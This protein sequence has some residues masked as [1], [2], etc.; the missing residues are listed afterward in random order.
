MTMTSFSYFKNTF[1]ITFVFIIV[2]KI[3]Y[4][5]VDILLFESLS[6]FNLNFLFR[7]LFIAFFTA[8]ILGVLNYFLKFNLLKKNNNN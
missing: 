6:D 8:L 2:Y 1:T 5:T 4:K 3:I 7:E